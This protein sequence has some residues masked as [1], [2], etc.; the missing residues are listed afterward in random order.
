[1]PPRLSDAQRW[2]IVYLFNDLHLSLH[3]IAKRIK[4]SVEGVRGVLQRHRES[5]TVSDHRRTGRPPIM[6]DQSLKRLDRI[7]TKHTHYTST[8]LADEMMHT[9]GQ[10]ISPR[11][12]RRARTTTLARHP[13]HEKVERAM[14]QGDMTRRLNFV[15]THI[16]NDFHHVIFSDEKQFVLNKTGTVH[17]IK[18]GEP[19]PT[20]EVDQPKA[21]VLVWGAVWYADKSS[22]HTTSKTINAQIYT[23]ILATHLLPSMPSSNRYVFQHDNARPHTAKH[24]K[25][26]LTQFAVNVL[27][28]WPPYSPDLNVIEHVWSWM[29]AYV[30]NRQPTNRAQLKNA[31]RL[32][33]QEIPQ[34]VI[35]SYIDKL[36]AVCRQIQSAGG[37]HL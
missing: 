1:M 33:W 36:P 19:I 26:W 14:T 17:W 24:T 11:T 15:T 28:D 4:C 35:Q 34:N 37:D 5:N 29:T 8:A 31:I 9:T 6:N 7:I 13:V 21:S 23:N 27:P 32:A 12:I 25:D 10:R 22:L 2:K 30:N 3:Q 18:K 20:R 16:N